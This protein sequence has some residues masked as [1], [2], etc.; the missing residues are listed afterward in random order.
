MLHPH[1]L[2]KRGLVA[3]W[4]GIEASDLDSRRSSLNENVV[5][6]GETVAAVCAEFPKETQLIRTTCAPHMSGDQDIRRAASQNEGLEV[7]R[8][9]LSVTSSLLMAWVRLHARDEAHRGSV[10]AS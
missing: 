10:L 1:R 3:G 7:P 9:V 2:G 5:K 6:Y 8:Q 4:R